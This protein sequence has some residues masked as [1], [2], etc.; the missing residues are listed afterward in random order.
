MS[1]HNIPHEDFAISGMTKYKGSVSPYD[2]PHITSFDQND[3][4]IR[5]TSI[6]ND[7]STRIRI[8]SPGKISASKI[9]NVRTPPHKRNQQR[10]QDNVL[11]NTGM[12]NNTMPSETPDSTKPADPPEENFFADNY[13][14]EA[15]LNEKLST[16]SFT[17]RSQPTP[18]PLASATTV[19]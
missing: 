10:F 11:P 1:Q 13:T 19:V 6:V 7:R 3:S 8:L 9:T 5:I 14:P 12:A 18:E 15:N 17:K 16:N 2:N 4:E